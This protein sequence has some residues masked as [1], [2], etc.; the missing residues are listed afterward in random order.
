MTKSERT[1]RLITILRQKN[2]ASVKELARLLQVSEMT[3]RRDMKW[4]S[5]CRRADL[6]RGVAVYRPD[7]KNNETV[8]FR[9]PQEQDAGNREKERIGIAAAGMIES[10]DT[11]FLD[12]GTEA[13]WAARYIP[14]NMQITA[15]CFSLNVLAEVQKKNVGQLIMSG[16]FYHRDTQVFECTEMIHMMR[17]RRP[18]KAFLGPAGASMALGLTCNELYEVEIKRV[19]IDNALQK[20]LLADSVKFGRVCAN[21]FGDWD[22]IDTVITDP[23]ITD[24][25]KDFLWDRG[26]KLM[27]V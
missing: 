26:I 11:V 19:G 10:G 15:L 12:V 13:A 16:G 23:G 2:A 3:V 1:D 14:Q 6:V 24:E 25:W 7:Q 20:I 9:L 18:D 8:P 22:Q 21:C 27:I 4:L 5:E 17:A